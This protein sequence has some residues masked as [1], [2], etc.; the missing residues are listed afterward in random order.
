MGREQFPELSRAPIYGWGASKWF[1]NKY[2]YSKAVLED[3]R[4]RAFIED[5]KFTK[6]N[7]K[8]IFIADIMIERTKQVFINIVTHRPAIIIGKGGETINRLKQDLVKFLNKDVHINVKAL[9]ISEFVHPKLISE[10]IAEQINRGLGYQRIL[11]QVLTSAM[12][13]GAIG[14]KIKI[15]GRLNNA[16]I[17]RSE[18]K[19][20]GRLGLTVLN[21]MII[22]HTK[23]IQT[24]NSGIIGVNIKVSLPK[25]TYVAA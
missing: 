1:L 13:N 16:T 25:G 24:R 11:R 3:F 22:S 23:H 19:T 18:F 15:G 2:Q 5:F 12:R 17:S 8:G 21:N 14:I 9:Q 20:E 6:E 10:A 4:I 7:E